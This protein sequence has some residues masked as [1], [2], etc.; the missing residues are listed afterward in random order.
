[1]TVINTANN[2]Q[3]L[4][5]FQSPEFRYKSLFGPLYGRHSVDWHWHDSLEFIQ[6]AQ[7]TA[8]AHIPQQDILLPE[9]SILLINSG[10]SHSVSAFDPSVP[11]K[12]HTQQINA[13]VLAGSI[14]GAVKTKY[15]DPVIRCS[16][17]P[18][19]IF[20]PEHPK[21]AIATGHFNKAF[22]AGQ[23]ED[24][25]FELTVQHEL[26]KIWMIFVEETQ[27]VWKNSA[28]V[29]DVRNDRLKLMLTFIQENCTEKLT[30]DQI[31][32][33]AGISCRECSR[34]FQNILKM[35]PIEYLTDCRV[36]KASELLLNSSMSI[37][38]ISYHCGFSTASYFCRIFK[39]TTGH[40]P[41]E[42]KRLHRSE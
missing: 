20:T 27:E 35:T 33:S 12:Y 15:F 1:M 41:S 6:I 40:S 13:D 4:I 18:V 22:S 23:Q 3:E 30:L 19:H 39:K 25:L 31:A 16:A 21:H 10:V 14:G 32:A 42:H 34:C 11:A 8:V 36:R 9:G 24:F 2:N 5:D 17:L 29:N 28:P 26:A 38:E 37:L 7:G